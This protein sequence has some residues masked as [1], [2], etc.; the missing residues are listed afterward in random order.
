MQGRAPPPNPRVEFLSGYARPRPYNS[1]SGPKNIDHKV[2]VRAERELLPKC[3]WKTNY[4]TIRMNTDI[5][6]DAV[7]AAGHLEI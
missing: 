3:T 7:S 4:N 5:L 2:R 6:V 1:P